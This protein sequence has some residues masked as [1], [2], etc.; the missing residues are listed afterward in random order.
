[1]AEERGGRRPSG[2]RVV[3]GVMRSLAL[4]ML[5]VGVNSVLAGSAPRYEPIYLLLAVIALIT[6]LD[7][8]LAGLIAAVVLASVYEVEFSPLHRLSWPGFILPVLS[9]FLIAAGMAVFRRIHSG[10]TTTA[11]SR[12]PEIGGPPLEPEESAISAAPEQLWSGQSVRPQEPTRIGEDHESL[13]AESAGLHQQLVALRLENDRLT[14]D[15]RTLERDAKTQL[16]QERARGTAREGEQGKLAADLAQAVATIR[17]LREEAGVAQQEITALHEQQQGDGNALATALADL[18]ALR[19]AAAASRSTEQTSAAQME[20]AQKRIR[21]LTEEL[22]AAAKRTATALDR[23]AVETTARV[24]KE[25]EFAAHEKRLHEQ[26]ESESEHLQ[27]AASSALDEIQ[28]V[29]AANDELRKSLSDERERVQSGARELDTLRSGSGALVHEQKEGQKEGQKEDL[30]A[31][32]ALEQE[33][34]SLRSALAEAEKRAHELAQ[35]R[36]VVL[37]EL[38]ATRGAE[39]TL[40]GEIEQLRLASTE[41]AK[42]VEQET[43]S[44][45]RDDELEM[46]LARESS[47]RQ[48]A[49]ERLHEW[50][51]AS[52]N[53][54]EQ[55]AKTLQRL[56][57]A[58][59]QTEQLRAAME[60]QAG[61]V[62]EKVEAAL[63]D[64]AR[65]LALREAAELALSRTVA[66]GEAQAQATAALRLAI[67]GHETGRQE[68]LR[69]GDAAAEDLQQARAAEERLRHQLDEERSRAASFSLEVEQLRERLQ[70][71]ESERAGHEEQKN[72]TAAFL[73][74][75][76]AKEDALHAQIRE[77]QRQL[78][79]SDQV[80]AAAAVAARDELEQ[81]W[82][83]KLQKIVASLASDHESDVGDL[84]TEREGARAEARSAHARLEELQGVAGQHAESRA[85]LEAR[86][87]ALE[88]NVETERARATEALASRERLDQEW[89]EKLQKIVTSLASDHE[90]DLGEAVMLRESARAEAR[91]L[92]KRVQLLQKAVQEAQALRTPLEE[93]TAQLGGEL[94]T[95]RRR[96]DEE[97]AARVRIEAEW[98]EKLQTIV[99][100]LASDHESDMGQALMDKEAAKAEVRTLGMR[101]HA[102]QQKLE[103]DREGLDK[104]LEKWNGVRQSLQARV[105]RA[106]AELEA[107]RGGGRGVAESGGPDGGTTAVFSAA[108]LDVQRARAEVL[109]VAEQAQAAFRRVTSSGTVRVPAARRPLVLIVDQDAEVRGMSREALISQGFDVLTA[110]DGL[111]GLR[112]AISHKPEIVIADASMPKMDGREL[113]QM[114]KSNEATAGVKVVL[115]TGSVTSAGSDQIPAG[116]APDTL[117]Q[118]PV[119][120]ETLQ[121]TLATLLQQV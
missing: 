117:L 48:E 36:D 61:R 83:D 58:E 35:S 100:H 7:G 102:L 118:K 43:T 49:E 107:F 23:A 71:A 22:G 116:L 55:L 29:R 4:G 9:G 78:A 21:D 42:S 69:A 120:P 67:T 84:L 59:A 17:K 18:A 6:W 37:A 114:I 93:R 60:E 82:S 68:L 75:S 20:A 30:A 44:R 63:A 121:M 62:N 113:C 39:E 50:Q 65:H 64:G 88:Q 31:R 74:A 101:V 77:L 85:S 111:E 47:L 81:E 103:A 119:R 16:A 73:D 70:S 15:S 79:E 26:Y 89:G 94:E 24:R 54:A 2:K 66:D 19:S 72:R 57:A 1:M 45:R 13:R 92:E 97:Q 99:S 112:I 33:R 25:E 96:A 108:S 11:A 76:G 115:M 10:G 51:S 5:A 110:S 3:R 28:R 40:R 95:E 53:D 27:T 32:M 98:S 46:A 91:S 41:S 56:A 90:N 104:A 109:E 8:L 105:T 80:S 52:S 34:D 12:Q 38:R 86:L 14:H 87:A 106:E